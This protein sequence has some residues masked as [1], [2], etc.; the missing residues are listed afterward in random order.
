MT[1]LVTGVAG[2]IGSHV[3]ESLIAHGYDIIGI[4]SFENFYPRWMKQENIN[5]LKDNPKFTL[6]EGDL[7]R[8]DLPELT[9]NAEYIF[10]LAAQAGVRSSW[11]IQFDAYTN[12]AF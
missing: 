12:N 9:K 1:A 5:V 10:H 3:A 8:L 6:V 4:D 7:L 11:G 2:F